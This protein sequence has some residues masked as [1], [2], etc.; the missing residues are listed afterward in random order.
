MQR[1]G[2]QLPS[3]RQLHPYLPPPPTAASYA[4]SPD[5]AGSPDPEHEHASEQ[6]GDER[7]GDDQPPKKRRRRQALSCTEC[8]RR[9]I[10]CDRAQPCAPCVRRGDQE[11]CQWHFVEPVLTLTQFPL[12]ER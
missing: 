8:K 1:P 12:Q 10:R 3:I 6:E 7:D 5:H 11:K 2:P 9:K 4:G